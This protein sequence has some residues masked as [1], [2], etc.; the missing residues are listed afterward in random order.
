[1]LPT[2]KPGSVLLGTALMSIKPGRIVVATTEPISI[3]R[4]VRVVGDEVWLEGDNKSSST[5]S[6]HYGPVKISDIGAVITKQLY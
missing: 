5:D 4:V 3:K 6:R 2:L 1:M